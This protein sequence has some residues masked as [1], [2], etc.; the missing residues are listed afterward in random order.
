MVE[1]FILLLHVKVIMLNKHIWNE[2]TS[3]E[4]NDMKPHRYAFK[5]FK[6]QYLKFSSS[7]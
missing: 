5:N 2:F 1:D 4:G 7:N 6:V 3:I